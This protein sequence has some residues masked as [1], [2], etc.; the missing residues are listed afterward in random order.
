VIR[1]YATHGLQPIITLIDS[2]LPVR[3]ET[4]TPVFDESEIVLTLLD[5]NEQGRLFKIRTW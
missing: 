5:E 2:D 1:R 4:E 3:A